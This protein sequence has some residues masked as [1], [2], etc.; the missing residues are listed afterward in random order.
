MD[1][2]RSA[3]L[4]NRWRDVVKPM[5][6]GVEEKLRLALNYYLSYHIVGLK[7]HERLYHSA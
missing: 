1:K 2:A 4:D 3:Y 5:L 7:S 6:S